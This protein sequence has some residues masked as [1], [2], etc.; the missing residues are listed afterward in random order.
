MTIIMIIS[1]IQVNSSLDSLANYTI[2]DTGG[3]VIGGGPQPFSLCNEKGD[4]VVFVE[5]LRET[6][7]GTNIIQIV[8]IIFMVSQAYRTLTEENSNKS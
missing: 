1:L 3:V 2:I 7:L 5:K 4:C 8:L 6:F